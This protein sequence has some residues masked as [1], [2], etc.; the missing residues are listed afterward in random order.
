MA[1]NEPYPIRKHPKVPIYLKINESPKLLGPFNAEVFPDL[2]I[3]DLV[4]YQERIMAVIGQTNIR[5]LDHIGEGY[6]DS[7]NVVF[8]EDISPAIAF[9]LFKRGDDGGN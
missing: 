3:G 9:K 6:G 8:L 5:M 4:M 1:I 2:T 7:A